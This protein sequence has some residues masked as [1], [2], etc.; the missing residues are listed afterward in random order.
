VEG[1]ASEAAILK[2]METQLGNVIKYRAKFPKLCEIPFNSS[3]KFQVSIH[4][5]RDPED[6]RHLLVMK[7][8]RSGQAF[9]CMVK[10]YH[11][12]IVNEVSN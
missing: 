1:D 4:D 11:N 3:N 2:C 7:V 5:M 8:N 9:F 10:C 6:P 12:K